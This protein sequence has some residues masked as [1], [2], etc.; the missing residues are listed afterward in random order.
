MGCGHCFVRRDSHL[1]IANLFAMSHSIRPFL[2]AVMPGWRWIPLSQRWNGRLRVKRQEERSSTGFC[3]GYRRSTRTA[4]IRRKTRFPMCV[5][6]PRATV[7]KLFLA[8]G[9]FSLWHVSFSSSSC[10]S[11]ALPMAPFRTGLR[12]A[13]GSRGGPASVAGSRG[14]RCIH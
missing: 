11:T 1:S 10:C 7:A 14:R 9:I 6:A 8:Y 12:P 3:R 13:C 4:T 5:L 2:A